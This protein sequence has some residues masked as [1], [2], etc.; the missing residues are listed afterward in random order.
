MK[1]N[2]LLIAVVFLFFIALITTQNTYSPRAET[3]TIVIPAPP[4][5]PWMAH[6]RF[7]VWARDLYRTSVYCCRGCELFVDFEV[8]RVT[9]LGLEWSDIIFRVIA[10]DGREVVIRERVYV[11]RYVSLIADQEG[12]YI[13]EFDN[14][15]SD[16]D[17]YVDL[18]VA[19]VPPP[20]TTTVTM[21]YTTTVTMYTTTQFITTTETVERT[22]TSTVTERALDT[23]TLAGGAALSLVVGVIIGYFIKKTK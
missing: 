4:T 17:K 13:L 16:F 22:L 2:A 14:T 1:A 21:R 9:W 7:R 3:V 6:Y 11:S 5:P 20:Q 10:P 12:E 19:V 23:S 15:Y 8:F 18:A